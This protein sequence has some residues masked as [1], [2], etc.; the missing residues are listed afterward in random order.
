MVS[1]FLNPTIGLTVNFVSAKYYRF[2][3]EVYI[4]PD[5]E[6]QMTVNNLA[7]AVARCANFAGAN[8]VS[9]NSFDIQLFLSEKLNG[10]YVQYS[11]RVPYTAR[12]C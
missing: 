3:D 5:I 1:I 9:I 10:V 7:D 8:L 4:F 2:D 11:G 6:D 12:Y